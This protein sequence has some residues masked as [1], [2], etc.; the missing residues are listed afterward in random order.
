MCDAEPAQNL[1]LQDVSPGRDGTVTKKVTR[2][3]E[4][5]IWPTEGAEVTVKLDV[6][7]ASGDI[8][9][10]ERELTFALA[11]G[12]YCYALEETVL[13]MK[14]GQICEVRCSDPSMYADPELGLSPVHGR[15]VVFVLEL[16]DFQQVDLYGLE[17][18]ERVQH[19]ARRKE[20]GTKFFLLGNWHRALKRYQHVISNLAY[21][22]HW[23]NEGAR[24]EALI[25]RRACHLNAAAC[26][27]K[28]EAWREA[29]FA[30]AEVL[31]E[32]PDNVKA[33][34]RRGQA[35]KELGEFR[36]AERSFRKV[37]EADK[38]NKEAARMLL[39]LRQSV[40][41]EIEQQK[42]ML[43]RMAKGI[44]GAAAEG[45][46]VADGAGTGGGES[47]AKDMA[48]QPE[49]PVAPSEGALVEEDR[50]ELWFW[51][52]AAL[53]L[54]GTSALAGYAAWRRLR[55]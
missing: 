55:R 25:L 29:E 35:L 53:V 15:A 39:K 51:G 49:A 14:K 54:A 31:H 6:R 17:E 3:S 44:S 7:D 37:L 28:L 23:K 33:L 16:L 20:V 13:T 4:D 27:L 18:D 36:E 52:F 48:V 50:S 40:K 41:C 5:Y 22:T 11:S 30:C 43:S 19:C 8:L 38:D 32:E 21:V 46:E 9:V 42:E 26:W 2:E 12:Q 45:N 1:T 24:S 10:A 34:F 47:L